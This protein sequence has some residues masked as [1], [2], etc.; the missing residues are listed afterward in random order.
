MPSPRMIS[1][2]GFVSIVNVD[3][4]STSLGSTPASAHAATHA[5]NA[6][7]SSLRPESLENS[8][9]PIPTIAAPPAY[10]CLTLLP[11][12]GQLEFDGAGQVRAKLV[13]G[14]YADDDAPAGGIDGLHAADK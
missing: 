14:L 13:G 11:S 10:E 5:S 2:S 12:L 4:P 9:A 3:S 7:C 1:L 8:V 6:S